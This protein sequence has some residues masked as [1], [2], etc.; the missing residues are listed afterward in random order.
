M[1]ALIHMMDIVETE[2]LRLF[3]PVTDRLNATVDA[4]IADADQRHD[5][6]AVYGNMPVESVDVA[7]CATRRLLIRLGRKSEW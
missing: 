5:I 2:E 7:A 3:V 1:I 4:C 6:V